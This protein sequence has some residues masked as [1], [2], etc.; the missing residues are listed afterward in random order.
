[1]RALAVLAAL[2]LGWSLG[3]PGAVMAQETE[4]SQVADSAKWDLTDLYPSDAA[5][6][7]AT[8]EFAT[9]LP[10]IQ[11]CSGTLGQSAQRLLGGLT[12]LDRSNKEFA[13]LFTYANLRLDEDMRAPAALALKQEVDRLGAEFAE[14]TAF[15]EPEILAIDPAVVRKFLD[16]EKR[17]GA[18]GHYLD[19][20]LRRQAH[21]LTAAEER[22]IAAGDL[23]S[24]APAD[25]RD[26][27]L[28]TDFPF[29]EVI[30]AEG[31]KQTLDP[32]TFS[33]LM[34]LPDREERRKAFSTYMVRLGEYR[35]TFGALLNAQYRGD[36]FTMKVRKYDSCLE[37]SLDGDHIPVRVY[38]ALVENVNRNLGTFHRYLKLRQRILGVR[39][40]H[41]YD[42]SAPLSAGAA[43]R[44]S[45]AEARK[46]V[47]AALEPLGADYVAVAERAFADRWIDALPTAGKRPGGY[48]NGWA[49]DVHPYIMFNFGGEY[50]DVSGIAHELG[51][52]VQS[53]MANARQPFATAACPRFVTEVASTFNEALLVDHLLKHTSDD[54][55]RLTMLANCLDGFAL[56]IFRA[57]LISEFELRAHQMVENGE[58]LNGDNL[59]DLYLAI[60]RK[61][62]GHD[63]HV[64]VVDDETRWGWTTIPQLYSGFYA[65]QY[66]TAFTASAALAERVL[67]GNEAARTKYLGFL[68][69]GGSDYAIALLQQAGTD[70]TSADPFQWSMAGMNRLLDE[71]ERILGKQKQAL[72]R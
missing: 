35:H 10:A 39:E 23:M 3:V 7:E 49:Y 36:L 46:L 69:A 37:A 14:K 13:R 29:P 4:R 5:W 53:Q 25:I 65:Y 67:Q 17:L 56:K 20:L 61:Y 30:G 2:I 72:P 52:A 57:T 21:T 18:F 31:G 55:L 24:G 50:D 9:G 51:H 16:G 42:L 48:A 70:M 26:A 60:V 68:S 33:R 38:T 6:K 54:D 11:A 40:L 15:F 27:F 62:Y 44:Y 19:D 12:L 43:R 45:F 41:S 22:I 32:S 34:Q 28:H 47:L 59:S 66:A 8:R 1:M 63:Q 58:P 71:M 64:C